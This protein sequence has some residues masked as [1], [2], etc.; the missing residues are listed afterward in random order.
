[1]SASRQEPLDLEKAPLRGGMTLLDRAGAQSRAGRPAVFLVTV[2]G[3]TRQNYLC[4]FKFDS[5]AGKYRPEPPAALP[6][7]FFTAKGAQG[8]QVNV[9]EIMSLAPCPGCGNTHYTACPVCGAIHCVR[10]RQEEA[11]CPRCGS[12]GPL[13]FSASPESVS[14]SPG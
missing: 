10:L 2:C 9:Q 6:E 13:D 3:K 11:V 7:D 12:R 14:G 5:D 1:M 8:P 4:R